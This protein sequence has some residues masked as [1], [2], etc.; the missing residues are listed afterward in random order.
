MR[1]LTKHLTEE[2]AALYVE[3]MCLDRLDMLENSIRHHV[4]ECT[5]CKQELVE[6]KEMLEEG[7]MMKLPK[8]HPYFG[9]KGA[10]HNVQQTT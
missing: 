3:A 2:E 1:T 9:R 5:Y 4:M 10:Q 6:I 7:G 8:N